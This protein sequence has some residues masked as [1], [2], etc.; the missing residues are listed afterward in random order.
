MF[1][2]EPGCRNASC[3]DADKSFWDPFAPH[4]RHQTTLPPPLEVGFINENY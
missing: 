4:A 1:R 3:K 2:P